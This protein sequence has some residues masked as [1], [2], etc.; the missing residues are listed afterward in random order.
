M[1]PENTTSH[2]VS[3]IPMSFTTRTKRNMRM[4]RVI[5]TALAVL[6]IRTTPT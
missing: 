5:L 3:I 1:G 6:P 2:N 4:Q